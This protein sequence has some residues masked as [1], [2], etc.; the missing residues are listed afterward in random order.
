MNKYRVC[1]RRKNG[2]PFIINAIKGAL[3]H[4]KSS[5]WLCVGRKELYEEGLVVELRYTTEQED[6]AMEVYTEAKRNLDLR[7]Y[8]VS[9]ELPKDGERKPRHLGGC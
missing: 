6:V 9:L 8:T 3:K 1:I 4:P 5:R 7:R 2:G